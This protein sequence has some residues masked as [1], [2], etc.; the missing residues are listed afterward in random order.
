MPL[1]IT[2]GTPS[3]RFAA[4]DADTPPTLPAAMTP[5]SALATA[6]T[7]PAFSAIADLIRFRRTREKLVERIET[8]RMPTDYGD[9]SLH[10][11]EIGRA[12]V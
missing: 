4:Y 7:P 11:Y 2:S 9:F 12:H 8:I 3:G 10:L 6:A 5:A 1:K